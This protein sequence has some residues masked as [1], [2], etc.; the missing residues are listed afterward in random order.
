MS[1]REMIMKDTGCSAEDAPMVEDIM[2]NDVFHSTLDWQT[3]AELRRGA[4]LAYQ[5]LNENR[6]EFE[7]YRRKTKEVFEEMRANSAAQMPR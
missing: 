5:V 4:R 7:E 1:Y 2:R 3:R 6:A